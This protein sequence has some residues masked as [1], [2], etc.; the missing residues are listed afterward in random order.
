MDFWDNP[1]TR[2][3]NACNDPHGTFCGRTRREFLWEAG[4]GFTGLALAGLLIPRRL[5]RRPAPPPTAAATPI[6]WPPEPPHFA[7]KAKSV[8]FLFMYGGP[9]QVDTFDYKPKLYAARRQD[10]RRSRPSAAAAT[11]NEG[12]VVGPEVEVQAVRPVRQVGQRPVPAPGH[13][14]RRHRLHPFDDRRLADPRLG[15]AA[16]EH[17]QDPVAAARAWARGS[18]T[19]WAA[20]TRTCPASWS[21]ST[22]PAGRSAAPR[23]GRAA[24]CRPLSGHDAPLRR[25]RRSST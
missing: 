25:R 6:R 12:R 23:T 24:T 10:D 22:R 14:R 1:D 5:L 8:I 3:N 7:P 4:G 18:T 15:H 19:A 11:K 2:T 20:S 21:C 17:G 16:D 13:L 9:S